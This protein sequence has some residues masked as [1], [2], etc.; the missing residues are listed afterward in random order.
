MFI[1]QIINTFVFRVTVKLRLVLWFKSHHPIF[2][3]ASVSHPVMTPVCLF[4]FDPQNLL[5]KSNDKQAVTKYVVYRT[6][7]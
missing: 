1:Q 6:D 3:M 7:T 4:E 5:E 2:A